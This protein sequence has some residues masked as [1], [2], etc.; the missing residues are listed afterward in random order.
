MQYYIVDQRRLITVNE[1][2]AR[3]CICMNDFFSRVVPAR[4]LHGD[5]ISV[6]SV[7]VP[8]PFTSIPTRSCTLL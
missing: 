1:T 4:G 2:D 6:P 3:D 7:R 8:A 5:G